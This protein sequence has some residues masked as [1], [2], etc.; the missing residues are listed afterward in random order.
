MATGPPK[1]V[2]TIPKPATNG[3]RL[4]KRYGVQARGT[5]EPTTIAETVGKEGFVTSKGVP[6][7]ADRLQSY[8]KIDLP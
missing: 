2:K 5:A 3:S 6:A 8:C 7:E 4:Q 1:A